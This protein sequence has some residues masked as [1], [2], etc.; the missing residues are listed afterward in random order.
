[1]PPAGGEDTDFSKVFLALHLPPSQRNECFLE[2]DDEMTLEKRLS[3][4]KG[5]IRCN[6]SVRRGFTTPQS[7][8]LLE[9]RHI[10]CFAKL[11]SPTS[12]QSIGV[13]AKGI[14]RIGML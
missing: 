13:T 7:D 10:S 9:N 8:I 11:N 2:T 1:M 12:S 4:I 5:V 14:R 3:D 6:S